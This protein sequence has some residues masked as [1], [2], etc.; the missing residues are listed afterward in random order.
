M[1]ALGNQYNFPSIIQRVKFNNSYKKY[2]VWGACSIIS[3]NFI[4]SFFQQNM[5]LVLNPK[6]QF[7]DMGEDTELSLIAHF[8][9]YNIYFSNSLMFYHDLEFSRLEKDKFINKK[10]K[11]AVKSD[12]VL[13]YYTYLLFKKKKNYYI[14]KILFFK[15]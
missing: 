13:K 15:Y 9:N 6:G 8:L 4:N 11:F 5:N 1:F 10:L 2:G 12:V 14:K 3:K 7:S